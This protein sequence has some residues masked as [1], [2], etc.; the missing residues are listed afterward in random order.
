MPAIGATYA[1][2]RALFGGFRA[3]LS[4]TA[5]PR[6]AAVPCHLAGY[7]VSS[8]RARP[9]GE[10]R[11]LLD[12]VVTACVGLDDLERASVVLFYG[13]HGSPWPIR[14]QSPGATLSRVVAPR[15]SAVGRRSRLAGRHA[16]ADVDYVLK[17][18][19][20]T[21][22]KSIPIR[23]ADAPWQPCAQG[24]PFDEVWWLESTAH[25]T[26][27]ERGR[28]AAEALQSAY[29]LV[30]IHPTKASELALDLDWW[31][32][33][34]R[35]R[36]ADP[37]LHRRP[38]RRINAERLA[39]A[40]AQMAIEMWRWAR[41]LQDGSSRSVGEGQAT[42]VLWLPDPDV[43]RFG[44]LVDELFGA[45][46]P[47]DGVED[48][49][50]L[51]ED[52]QARGLTPTVPA[53]LL[54]WAG[55]VA[56]AHVGAD[57]LRRLLN[58]MSRASAEIEVLAR[59]GH[60]WLFALL[61]RAGPVPQE[62]LS[63][64]L[65]Q[66]SVASSGQGRFAESANLLARARRGAS[67]PVIA[68]KLMVG[69]SAWR[70]RF[71]S[72][73]LRDRRAPRPVAMWSAVGGTWIHGLRA[74]GLALTARAGH[75]RREGLSEALRA[76]VRLVEAD[77]LSRALRDD[78]W[79][80]RAQYTKLQAERPLLR[81]AVSRILEQE[82]APGGALSSRSVAPYDRA[83]AEVMSEWLAGMFP[84]DGHGAGVRQRVAQALSDE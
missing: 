46:N 54:A 55:P 15:P 60:G 42:D 31:A 52:G 12:D 25:L 3:T 39:R 35:S 33:R 1:D 14:S 65:L 74:A 20:R 59:A 32:F 10:V 19:L 8:E 27:P 71:L 5:N 45:A 57:R 47:M 6:T 53:Q 26:A 80:T 22:A 68:F 77:N 16:T 61:A 82:H 56:M 64:M 81:D 67:D 29:A 48:A 2:I 66:L 83:R 75:D 21:I 62:Q 34:H 78:G 30:S 49:L 43:M 13:L 72:G 58:A 18:A 70:R 41:R 84:T 40:N 23:A 50:R 37:E 17:Q 63:E 79:L 11:A 24:S 76:G 7:L 28:V 51:I 38:G 36:L 4:G 44:G 73:T 9:L 69:E